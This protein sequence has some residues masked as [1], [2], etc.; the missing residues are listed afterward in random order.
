MG[1]LRLTNFFFAF[2]NIFFWFYIRGT[3]NVSKGLLLHTVLNW[4]ES[5]LR[6]HFDPC[7]H[8]WSKKRNKAS[9]EK[10]VN[11]SINRLTLLFPIGARAEV[12]DRPTLH[13]YGRRR[14]SSRASGRQTKEERL[15]GGHQTQTSTQAPP[16]I[17]VSRLTW[18]IIWHSFDKFI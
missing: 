12:P 18:I 14:Q 5:L 10:V 8:F 7:A 6:K 13:G 2:C 16:H 4:L 15:P 11:Q 17:H 9:G 3:V 1:R